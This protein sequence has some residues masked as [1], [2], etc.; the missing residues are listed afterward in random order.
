LEVELKSFVCSINN[1]TTRPTSVS[2]NSNGLT[3]I[4][5]KT[6]F[7]YTIH[8]LQ[9]HAQQKIY[10]PSPGTCPGSL[11]GKIAPVYEPKKIKFIMQL[12]INDENVFYLSYFKNFYICYSLC[13][14]KSNIFNKSK[15]MNVL[16]NKLRMYII[17]WYL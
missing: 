7:Y 9:P 6:T 16:W 15:I 1:T 17:R 13:H 12:N 10:M 8:H 3:S 5:I 4:C 2:C 11:G 14:I